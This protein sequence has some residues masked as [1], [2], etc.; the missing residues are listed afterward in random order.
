M[1]VFGTLPTFP[2]LN[3]SILGHEENMKALRTAR[4]EE[5]N[6]KAGQAIRRAMKHNIQQEAHYELKSGDKM[7]AYI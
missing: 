7:Y 2:I 1:L 3:K 6:I 5:A 4:D